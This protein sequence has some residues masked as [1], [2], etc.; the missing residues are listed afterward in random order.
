MLIA[1]V[2]TCFA[3]SANAQASDCGQPD[4]NHTKLCASD[5]RINVG[6]V[7]L[8]VDLDGQ[9]TGSY[10]SVKCSS[11]CSVVGFHVASV[12]CTSGSIA[13]RMG[14]I[15]AKLAIV[16]PLL[17]VGCSGGLTPLILD[18]K[19]IEREFVIA[20]SNPFHDF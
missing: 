19:P 8:T 2:F 9:Y 20:S 18:P 5:C 11:V 15:L 4:K 6:A 16:H 14:P 7:S 10:A 1:F 3:I 12:G 13:P 17:A